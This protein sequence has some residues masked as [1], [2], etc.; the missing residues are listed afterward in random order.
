[1]AIPFRRSQRVREVIAPFRHGTISVVVGVGVN[2]V[3]IVNLDNWHPV[4]FRPSQL[5]LL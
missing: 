1:M 3:I 5:E 2:A 4:R